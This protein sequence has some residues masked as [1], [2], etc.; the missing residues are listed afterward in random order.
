MKVVIYGNGQI[1]EVAY[2]YLKKSSL[3]NIVGF[4]VQ[5][6]FIKKNT[7]LNLPVVEYEN[8]EEYYSPIDFKLFAPISQ[9]KLNTFREYI[10]FDSK[11]RGYEFISYVDS[12]AK[13]ETDEIGEN[14]FI[15][16]GNNIQPYTKIG[17]N[18]ILWSGNHIGH[19]SV[20]EDNV[21]ITSH[22]VVSGDCRIK[23]NCF[24]GVNASIKDGTIMEPYSTLGMGGVLTKNTEE[25]GIYVGN[26]AKLLK[27]AEGKSKKKIDTNKD[28]FLL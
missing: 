9:H 2:W 24:V 16:E 21:F 6:E 23:K 18:C 7:F 10:Y 19:H 5:K 26:P 22:V 14:C 12:T 20:I 13:I 8:L 11:R 17:N 25:Y 4:T 28:V 3:Y 1:A 15:F 27:F